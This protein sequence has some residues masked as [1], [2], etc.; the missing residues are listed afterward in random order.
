MASC[1]FKAIISYKMAFSTIAMVLFT[2]FTGNTKANRFDYVDVKT[3]NDQVLSSEFEELTETLIPSMGATQY[4][5]FILIPALV[6]QRN[7]FKTYMKHTSHCR[8]LVDLRSIN[9][10]HSGCASQSM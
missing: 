6:S 9:H 5:F 1:K 3:V 10:H 7:K 4:D 8:V 2:Y